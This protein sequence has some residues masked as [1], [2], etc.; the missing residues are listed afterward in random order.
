MKKDQKTCVK[1]FRDKMV[2]LQDGKQEHAELKKQVEE[3]HKII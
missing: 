2:K 3:K 1:K